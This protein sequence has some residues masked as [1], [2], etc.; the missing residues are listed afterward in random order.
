M[1]FTYDDLLAILRK[2]DMTDMADRWQRLR[3][4]IE[5]QI[6]DDLL[7]M[8]GQ[9]ALEK[10]LWAP[11]GGGDA[12]TF[13]GAEVEALPLLRELDA[14]LQAGG[15]EAAMALWRQ[16]VTDPGKRAAL[17]GVAA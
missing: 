4:R 9:K 6:R 11:P 8:L 5:P 12:S 10:G 7:P 13:S 2:A 16:F 17:A 14:A 15:A 1:Q 3:H